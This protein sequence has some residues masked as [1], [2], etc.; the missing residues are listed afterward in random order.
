MSWELKWAKDLSDYSFWFVSLDCLEKYLQVEQEQDLSVDNET[1]WLEDTVFV[2]QQCNY[3]TSST[4]RG[5]LFPKLFM[6]YEIYYHR[7]TVKFFEGTM[8]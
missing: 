7:T 4:R 3:K 8:V 5:F 1:D 2:E 6:K